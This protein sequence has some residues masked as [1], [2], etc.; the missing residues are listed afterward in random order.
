MHK[1][2]C[3]HNNY[4]PS[5]A[6]GEAS[7][8]DDENINYYA[9][10]R[11]RHPR[12]LRGTDERRY[13]CDQS[14]VH[15]GGYYH[16]IAPFAIR[17]A[18]LVVK[19]ISSY[20]PPGVIHLS[21]VDPGVGGARR[22]IAV[23]T[24]KSLFVGPDNGLFSYILT[25][26]APWQ[27]REI[28]N[29]ALLMPDPHPTFHGRDIFAPVS[30]FLSA[31]AEFESIGPILDDPIVLPC[32]APQ[33][34]SSGVLGE[35]IYI[36]RF[37][38]ATTNIESGMLGHAV[39]EVQVGH[40]RILGLSRCFADARVG[41]PL[42]LINSFGFLEIAINGGCAAEELDIKVGDYVNVSWT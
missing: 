24:E 27:A 33:E 39:G 13:P 1:L 38:N 41:M 4:E 17:E 12:W 15:G 6:K 11:F 5:K 23:K 32:P 40:T 29:E 22:P 2:F 3:Y 8:S 28:T 20:F 16:D 36:D 18:A 19:G 25:S 42:A 10:H 9:D 21:V 7:G 34:T 31:G 35:V 37:G 30:A 14:F 26:S